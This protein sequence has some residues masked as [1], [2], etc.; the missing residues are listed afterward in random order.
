MFTP[1]SLAVLLDSDLRGD[2]I[3]QTTGKVNPRAVIE[4]ENGWEDLPDELSAR[5]APARIAWDASIERWWM[6]DADFVWHELGDQDLQTL[7]AK[8]LQ[9]RMF[10]KQGK[11]Y[12]P[13]SKSGY[14]KHISMYK[15]RLQENV[16]QNVADAEGLWIG[17]SDGD[18][19][20]TNN[21]NQIIVAP[22]D[23]SHYIF[24]RM[25]IPVYEWMK[26]N[27]PCKGIL[28]S[29]PANFLK[30]LEGRITPREEDPQASMEAGIGM[31]TTFLGSIK[32]GGGPILK[33]AL[34]IKGG[35]GTGKSQ[36]T[37]IAEQMIPSKLRCCIDPSSFQARFQ[38]QNLRGKWANIVDEVSEADV[39]QTNLLKTVL[40]CGTISAEMKGINDQ[41]LWAPKATH[42][43]GSNTNTGIK[44]ASGA[45]GAVWDRFVFVEFNNPIRY[46]AEDNKRGIWRDLWEMEGEKITEYCIAQFICAI[47]LG[48]F[49]E[50]NKQSREVAKEIEIDADPLRSWLARTYDHC[51]GKTVAVG[52]IFNGWHSHVDAHKAL[53][54]YTTV[55]TENKMK[56]KLQECYPKSLKRVRTTPEECAAMGVEYTPRT[57]VLLDFDRIDSGVNKSGSITLLEA[58][59]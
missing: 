2:I 34:M 26:E 10:V 15:H 28:L 36:V 22:K 13:A 3:D 44:T 25:K 47:R 38:L 45:H 8:E 37:K 39:T 18:V 12:V 6:C 35:K 54:I 14:L 4:C 50:W 59:E 19:C 21:A 11:K 43:F 41:L 20:I 48:W 27:D 30:F 16:S 58:A 42:I 23:P 32:V 56:D 29:R 33:H 46:T 24:D 17:F 53:N 51:P 52:A 40:Q 31:I 57:W 7:C 55:K 1:S 49:D 9:G 5:I